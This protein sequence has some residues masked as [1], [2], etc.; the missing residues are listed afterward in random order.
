MSLTFLT[1]AAALFAV[2][3]LVV[4]HEFGHFLAAKALGVRVIVFSIGFGKRLWGFKWGNTDYRIST[5]PF[6]GYVRMSH[7]DPFGDGGYF[8]DEDDSTPRTEWFSLRPAWHRLI[9]MFAGPL[10]N[11]LLPF[12]L[13]TVLMALGEPQAQSVVGTVLAGSPA[14]QVGLVEGDRL[15][16]V[17][18]VSVRTWN[19]VADVMGSHA[20][21][22]LPLVVDR[23]GARVQVELPRPASVGSVFGPDDL[24]VDSLAPDTEIGVDDPRS[25]AARAGLKTGDAVLAVGGVEVRDYNELSTALAAVTTDEV[26][27]RVVMAGAGAPTDVTLSRAVGWPDASTPA[28]DVVWQRWG[29]GSAT[30]FVEDFVE[31]SAARDAGV[32]VGDRMVMADA[33][34]VHRFTDVLQVVSA[35]ASGIGADQTARAV[36]LT[37]RREGQIHHFSLQPQ[38]ERTV[39]SSGL[40]MWRPLIGI[41]GDGSLVDARDIPRAYPV[42]EAFPRAVDTTL[43]IATAIV[44]RVGEMLTLEA[45]VLDNLGGPVAM[46]SQAKAAAELGPFALGRMIAFFSI[47]LFVLNLLPIPVLD[48]GS[49]FMYSAEWLRGRPLPRILQERAQQFGVVF[50]VLLTLV[51]LANDS[52]RLVKSW[53]TQG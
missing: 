27:L 48:G 28:D 20:G 31:Q 16:E 15:V 13:F 5:L 6:G 3:M 32:L 9:I 41:K 35:A 4:V 49:I 29:I 34:P 39:T 37:V 42:T 11:L 44:R 19:D 45:P 14:E 53:F 2:A 10:A 40:Y 25:P 18:G 23:N 26:V 47:S 36:D 46:V 24:G 21:A 52:L 50:L 7:A 8:D 43:G 12:G 30:W 1:T 51:V 17:D 22:T 33:Q 38:V